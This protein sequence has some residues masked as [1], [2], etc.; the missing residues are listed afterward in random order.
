MSNDT[1]GEP[2]GEQ[3]RR[4]VEFIAHDLNHLVTI[5]LV[6]NELLLE[7][8]SET[9]LTAGP[10]RHDLEQ[11]QRAANRVASL[12]RQL[13]DVRAAIAP[14]I[15]NLNTLIGQSEK[16]IRG[17]LGEEISLSTRLYPKLGR[18]KAIPEQIDRVLLNLAMNASAAM[19]AGGEVAIATA[20]VEL[21]ASAASE[22]R[23][24]PGSYVQVYFTDNGCGMDVQTVSGSGLGLSIVREIVAQAGGA[25]SIRSAPT[26]GA[27]ITI[28]F[29]RIAEAGARP[30]DGRSRTILVAEDDAQMRKLIRVTLEDAGYRVL[31]AANGEQATAILAQRG[32]DLMLVDILMPQKDGLETIGS[33][34]KNHR[35]V[36]TIAI[37]GAREDYLQVARLLGAH[38]VIGKPFTREFLVETVRGLLD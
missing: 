12:T 23:V 18:V 34:R 4:R 21:D 19:R 26:Q 11:I 31:E 29:P 30:G 14:S 5:I 32:I 22:W 37:S 27:A 33:A 8:T 3:L 13:Q 36:K 15:V 35:D 6:Y 17:V 28:L 9:G 1:P 16:L 24:S 25:I 7:R 2:D 20:N 10:N 38:A